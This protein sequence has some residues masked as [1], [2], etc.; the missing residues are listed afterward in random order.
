MIWVLGLGCAL[1]GLFWAL[2]SA[3]RVSGGFLGF[4][5]VVWTSS[6][7][8][9]CFWYWGR[10]GVFMFGWFVG[11]CCVW[12]GLGCLCYRFDCCVVWVV[13]DVLVWFFVFGVRVCLYSCFIF[14]G[15]FTLFTSLY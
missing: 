3:F 1:G 9:G 8:Y 2:G 6:L 13:C 14:L 15:L 4:L 12:F 5:S 10:L 11:G 7:G